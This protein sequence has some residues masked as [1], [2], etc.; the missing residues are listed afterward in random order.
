VDKSTPPTY[1]S[2]SVAGVLTN[3]G[4]GTVTLTN[5]SSNP[6]YAFAAG[7]SFT[8]F[9]K[10]LANGAA[11]SIAPASPGPGLA[12]TNNLAIDGTI[13]V[14]AAAPAITSVAP[15]PVT[16]SSFPL[17]FTLNGGGFVSGC[18][19]LLTNLD[20]SAGYSLPATFISASQVTAS[21][22]LGTAPHN[23][24]ATVLNPGPIAS[25]QAA[26]VAT[27]PASRP[28]ITRVAA[29]GH[30]KLILSGIN[31]STPAYPYALV[32]TTNVS[33]SLL[34]WTRLATNVFDGTGAFSCTNAIDPAKPWFFCGIQQ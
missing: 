2:V 12:W 22:V 20:T 10:A 17:T 25:G 1:G 14:V 8:L 23:W 9:N 15:N 13:G 6:A 5:L 3:A 7:D 21:A 19:V 33:Q 18:T 26:F 11:L 16:G 32:G 28:Q 30:T 31:G 27:A 4:V 29:P 34:L 24:N